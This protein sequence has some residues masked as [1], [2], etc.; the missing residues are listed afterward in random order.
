MTDL[1]VLVFPTEGGARQVLGVVSDLQRQQPITLEDA[2]TVVHGLDAKPEEAAAT[3]S[4][5]AP[6]P[7]AQA[8]VQVGS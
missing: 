1:I 8:A 4:A 5:A 6:T 7:A 3:T 2:A